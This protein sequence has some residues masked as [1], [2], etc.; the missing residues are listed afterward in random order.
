MVIEA[1]PERVELK[2]AVV[3]D[4]DRLADPDAILSSNSSSI[5]TSQVIDQVQHPERVLNT[6]YQMPRT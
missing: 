4:L 1:I 6:H 3:A 5:P 2:T